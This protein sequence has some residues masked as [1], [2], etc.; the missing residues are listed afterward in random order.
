MADKTQVMWTSIAVVAGVIVF[1]N[2]GGGGTFSVTS[3]QASADVP[4]V[5]SAPPSPAPRPSAPQLAQRGADSPVTTTRSGE[6]SIITYKTGEQKIDQSIANAR[7]HL[8]Y[9][10]DHHL[11]PR[12]G[13]RTF[14]LKVAFPVTNAAGAK[15]REHIWVLYPTRNGAT[16]TGRLDNDP[17]MMPGKSGDT[18]TFTEDM[19]TDWGFARNGKMIGFYSTR[20]M[21]DDAPPAEA[22]KIRMMLGENPA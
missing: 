15:G 19:V 6:P 17:D 3:K 8:A 9:F 16:F 14:T 4:V 21:L 7:A 10:W 22:A 20:A 18:V 12:P 5:Q 13:E 11:N 2:M 1:A